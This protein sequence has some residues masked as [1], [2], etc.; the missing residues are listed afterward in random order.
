MNNEIAYAKWKSFSGF[1]DEMMAFRSAYII[2][3]LLNDGWIEAIH[4]MILV[5]SKNS[6]SN[7]T[8]GVLFMLILFYFDFYFISFS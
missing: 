8:D 2:L 6:Q 4:S 5:S 3:M 7:R 1:I